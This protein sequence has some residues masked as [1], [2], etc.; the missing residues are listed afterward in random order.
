MKTLFLTLILLGLTIV[1]FSQNNFRD[2]VHL[3]NGSIIK[4]TVTEMVPD[5]HI[6]FATADGG[7]SVYF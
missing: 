5:K 2:V 7:I 4:G 1:S 6:K 3:K